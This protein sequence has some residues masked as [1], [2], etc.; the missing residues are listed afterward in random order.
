MG[1]GSNS[2]FSWVGRLRNIRQMISYEISFFSLFIY[3]FIFSITFSFFSLNFLVYKLPTI[4]LILIIIISLAELNRAPFDFSEGESELVSGFNTEYFSLN[5]SLI[6]LVEYGIILFMSY[7]IIIVN[8]NRK[9]ILFY[10]IIY[11]WL[12]GAIPRCR[13]DY[14]L[15]LNWFH[16]FPV[17]I[18]I[19]ALSYLF[20]YK[21]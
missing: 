21:R 2:V 1:A 7:I 14:L 9:L 17:I 11:V 10:L 12:R 8:W 15:Y 3:L 20:L 4:G 19:L 13:Y 6:F 16:L 18:L 5:F